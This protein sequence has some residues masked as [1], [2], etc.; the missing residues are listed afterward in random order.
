MKSILYIFPFITVEE[1]NKLLKAD[2]ELRAKDFPKW[3]R[4]KKEAEH[5]LQ[6]GCSVCGFKGVS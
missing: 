2:R 6:F 4:L 1:Y 3:S 5:R